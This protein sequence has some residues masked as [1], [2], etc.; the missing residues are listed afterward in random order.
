ME[1]NLRFAG[2]GDDGDEDL[3]PPLGLAELDLPAPERGRR[4]G[5][6][7]LYGKPGAPEFFDLD[8]DVTVTTSTDDA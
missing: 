7:T 1:A 3:R 6:L 4:A 8:E 2:P 5:A